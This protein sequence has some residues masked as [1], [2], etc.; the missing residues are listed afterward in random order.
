MIQIDYKA[1]FFVIVFL[2]GA[3][4][5]YWRYH[6]RCQQSHLS[7]SDVS[8]F[9]GVRKNWRLK[10]NFLPKGLLYLTLMLFIAAFIDPYIREDN[11]PE[12]GEEHTG[13][14]SENKRIPTEGIAIYF[15]LDVS[16]SMKDKVHFVSPESGEP[17][18]LTKIEALKY[19]TGQFIKGN[20]WLGLNGQWGN[21][22]GLVK[23][24]RVAEVI[25][26]PT[27]LHS[28][29]LERLSELTVVG[30]R[31]RDGTAIGYAI[32]KTA[33]LIEGA[34]R[35]T[36]EKESPYN[37][38][39]TIMILVTDGLQS[40]H[41]EDE[42]H[43][44]RQ[45]RVK[46]AAKKA[47]EYGVKLYIVNIEPAI[48]QRRFKQA[49][50]E[51]TEASKLTGGNFFVASSANNLQDIYVEIDSLEKSFIG[52]D[53]VIEKTER[54]PNEDF[55]RHFSFYPSL[56]LAGILSLFASVILHTMIFRRVP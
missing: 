9:E 36:K 35:F 14:E 19:I 31:N 16:S 38:K 44:M 20:R 34:R 13:E 52:I 24:A 47:L 25:S 33:S 21:M 12:G 40:P 48:L 50:D 29:I 55:R 28:E 49:R 7:Y 18:R 3:T 42:G 2:L 15:V 23:F 54:D 22:I 8:P 6:R 32:Y 43:E 4:L 1:L 26:P 37:I 10:L 39:N 45:M 11:I 46:E 17:Y 51:L 41:P 27:L 53:A 5:L 30:E 56:I